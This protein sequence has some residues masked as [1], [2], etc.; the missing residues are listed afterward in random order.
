LKN[1]DYSIGVSAHTVLLPFCE[2]TALYQGAISWTD[3]NKYLD[4]V[5]MAGNPAAVRVAYLECPSETGDKFPASFGVGTSNYVYCGGDWQDAA[6]LGG[7]IGASCSYDTNPRSVF[8]ARYYR[9]LTDTIKYRGMNA[10]SD[11]TSNTVALS[12]SCQ[13]NGNTQLTRVGVITSDT[14]VVNPINPTLVTSSVPSDCLGLTAGGFYTSAVDAGASA[15]KG[16]QWTQGWPLSNSFHTIL[17]PNGPTCINSVH[18]F[19]GPAMKSAG[20]YHPGGVNCALFDGSVRFVSE[21]V[22]CVSSGYTAASA[23]IV[24]NGP[25]QFGVWGALGSINGSES[26]SLP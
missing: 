9:P 7:N 17:P 23:R 25:S 20:S 24:A 2:Q 12:E 1:V 10:V 22:S 15:R 6:T 26:Q 19:A 8:N 14:A 18:A 21:T 13:G 3:L 16:T 4:D 5:T 11:G